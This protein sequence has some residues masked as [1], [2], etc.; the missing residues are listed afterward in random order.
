MCDSSNWTTKKEAQM[1]YLQGSD[2]KNSTCFMGDES[3]VFI[4]EANGRHLKPT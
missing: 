3:A 4:P 1:L 2:D